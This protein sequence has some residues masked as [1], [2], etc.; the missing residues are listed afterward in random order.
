MSEVLSVLKHAVFEAIAADAAAS[1]KDT[2]KPPRFF[3]NYFSE[4]VFFAS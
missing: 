4:L 3:F 1:D 2:V